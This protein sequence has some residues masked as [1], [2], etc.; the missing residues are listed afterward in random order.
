[1]R[2]K[3]WIIA[4]VFLFFLSVSNVHGED[5]GMEDLDV[6]TDEYMELIEGLPLTPT[7]EM[8]ERARKSTPPDLTE[9]I[10]REKERLLREEFTGVKEYMDT[11]EKGYSMKQAE[12]TL[13]R[14]D[15]RIYLF[16][17]SS[18][19]VETLRNYAV[20][21]DRLEGVN[22]PMVLRGFVDGMTEIKPTLEF[23]RDIILKDRDCRGVDCETHDV[24]VMIDPLLF[25]RYGIESVPAIVYARGVN[26]TD[27]F[28]SEGLEESVG[29]QEYYI[30]YGDSS[31][32]HLI[33]RINRTVKSKTLGC[34]VH[35]L[36]RG[37]VSGHLCR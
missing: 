20:S 34:L 21:I 9:R 2:S 22:I 10:E 36:R 16:I 14:D 25:R 1:M 28:A 4:C 24:E 3:T 17:S 27:A 19:P 12:K 18:I 13:L 7:P 26:V 23:V 30:L 6:D 5:F 11:T 35:R 32:D 8:L 31:L 15:E 37:E 29:V 33:E